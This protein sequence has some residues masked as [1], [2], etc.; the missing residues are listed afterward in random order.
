MC[1]AL[2]SMSSG[3]D[4][5][6]DDGS[7]GDYGEDE[8]E[9]PEVSDLLAEESARQEQEYEQSSGIGDSWADQRVDGK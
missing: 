9:D 6:L 3:A 2:D 8:F 7:D 5:L 4:G 1:E